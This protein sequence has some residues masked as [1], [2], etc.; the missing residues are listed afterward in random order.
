MTIATSAIISFGMRKTAIAGGA[1]D[2]E[3]FAKTRRVLANT[4]TAG[5]E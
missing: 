3:L 2:R 1:E 5:V 4:A